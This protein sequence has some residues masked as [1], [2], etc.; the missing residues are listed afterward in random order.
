MCSCCGHFTTW[1]RNAALLVALQIL[2]CTGLRVGRARFDG[3]HDDIA[4]DTIRQAD[5]W[6]KPKWPMYMIPQFVTH[7]LHLPFETHNITTS[8]G[9]HL[10]NHRLPNEGGKPVF[11][12]HPTGASSATW[13]LPRRQSVPA[14]LHDHGY[15]VWLGNLRGNYYS[16]GH[17]SLSMSDPDF[18]DW[19]IIDAGAEDLPEILEYILMVT[20][21]SSISYVGSS[22]GTTMLWGAL[23]RPE[24]RSYVNPIINLFVAFGPVLCA[25]G[26]PGWLKYMNH[27]ALLE[28]TAG[29]SQGPHN[30]N[31]NQKAYSQEEAG[32]RQK[33]FKERMLEKL[34]NLKPMEHLAEHGVMFAVGHLLGTSDFDLT[35]DSVPA[36]CFWDPAGS[37][38]GLS[39]KMYVHAAQQLKHQDTMH[40]YDYGELGNLVAYG[41]STAPIVDM[42]HVRVP[43]ALFWGENDQIIGDPRNFDIVRK[44][45]AKSPIVWD[46]VYKGYS[47][48]T[49][50]QYDHS[51]RYLDQNFY[52]DDL[53]RLLAKAGE[54]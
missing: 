13:F 19:T 9:Y 33:T 35:C 27:S 53:L 6:P 51:K 24:S 25:V 26:T 17:R 44:T 31:T 41:Q 2:C 50:F 54:V 34:F 7:E 30:M 52:K 15:D 14:I 10:C 18:W 38:D 3:S 4:P 5:E 40:E 49:F 37:E 23:A 43:T 39:S 11:L 1:I 32:L 20:K 28:F 42:S 48:I 36:P 12:M 29:E 47:H 21:H 45:L 16:Q 22:I 46:K 8:R